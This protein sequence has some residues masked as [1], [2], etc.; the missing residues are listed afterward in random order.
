MIFFS[1]ASSEAHG[2]SIRLYERWS[3]AAA[4]CQDILSFALAVGV[5]RRDAFCSGTNVHRIAGAYYLPSSQN[6]M[7]HVIGTKK[8][9]LDEDDHFRLFLF[10]SS[11]A[12]G[13][14]H[15]LCAEDHVS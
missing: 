7:L 1:F 6:K 5:L 4:D 15:T 12:M 8:T 11:L 2:P 9:D 10:F 14:E 3:L 13:N